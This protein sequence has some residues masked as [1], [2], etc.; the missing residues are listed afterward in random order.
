MGDRPTFSIADD[1]VAMMELKPAARTVYA[2][3]RCNTEFGRNGV[4][5][6][7]V[8]VTSLWFSEMTAHWEKPVTPPTARRGL[9]E[10]IDKGVLVRLNEPQDGSGFVVAFV[11]DPGPQYKGPVN[12]FEHAKRVSK[13]CGTKALYERRDERP[14]TPAITGVR[15]GA[16]RGPANPPKTNPEPPVWE[17]PGRE[18]FE[19]FGEPEADLKGGAEGPEGSPVKT[20][21]PEFNVRQEE[22]AR[23]LVQKCHGKGVNGRGLLEGEARR[24]AV[25]YAGRLDQGWSPEQIAS[26]LASLVSSKIHSTEAFLKTKA[27]DFGTPPSGPR[28]DGVVEI[29]GQPVDLS[30]YQLWGPGESS[31]K[32]PEIDFGP[33]SS[34]DEA[35]RDRLKQLGRK[36]RRS[37]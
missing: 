34:D 30:S 27:S 28:S 16:Q 5:T 6:H 33:A 10:L 8:H 14:S 7:A 37:L 1:Y 32:K 24:V 13:R 17:E 22:L 36:V 11:T 21:E 3:L 20:G 25:S 9:N 2:I 29:N 23:L 4:P 35:K 18:E 19:P 26:K 31:Q 15:V 12:G